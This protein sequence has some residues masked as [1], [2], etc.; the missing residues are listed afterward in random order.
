MIDGVIKSK[1]MWFATAT[2]I[3]GALMSSMPLVQSSI[4]QEYYGFILMGLGVISAI[5][6]VA[7]TKPLA[8]K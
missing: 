1:T 8:E 2:A 4:S 7:T 6:R 3:I 5:L